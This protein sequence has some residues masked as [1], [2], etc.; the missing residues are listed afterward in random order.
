MVATHDGAYAVGNTMTKAKIKEGSSRRP[1]I[2]G[3]RGLAVLLVLVFHAGATRFRGGFI[4]VDVFFVISGFVIT[5]ALLRELESSG[6]IA[7]GTFYARRARR[8]IPLASIVVAI[9]VIASVQLLPVTTIADSVQAAISASLFTGNIFFANQQADYFASSIS[10]NPLLHYWSL[11]VEE[12][13]YLIWPAAMML[14]W[15]F[16]KTRFRPALTRLLVLVAAGSL[17]YCVLLAGS[18]PSAVFFLLPARALQLAAG[19]LLAL[20]IVRIEAGISTRNATIASV[21]GFALIMRSALSIATPESWSILNYLVPVAGTLLV[22]IGGRHGAGWWLSSAL[23]EGIGNISFSLYLIHW[24]L[25]TIT[26]ALLGRSLNLTET[27]LLLMLAGALALFA[28]RHLERPIRYS[29]R[30]N[31]AAWKGLAVGAAGILLSLSITSVAGAT[32]RSAAAAGGPAAAPRLEGFATGPQISVVPSNLDPALVDATS[33]RRS[34]L[35]LFGGCFQSAAESTTPPRDRCLFGDRT[36]SKAVAVLGDSHAAHWLPALTRLGAEQH[37]S[38]FIAAKENCSSVGGLVTRKQSRDVYQYCQ[39]YHEQTIA[40]IKE[41]GITSVILASSAG[42]L[43][44]QEVSDEY[45]AKLQELIA[46]F[47]SAAITSIVLGDSPTF[48][49]DVPTCLAIS[50][51]IS[52]CA[53]RIDSQEAKGLAVAE[54]N[55]AES[56]GAGYLSAARL[57]CPSDVCPLIAGNLLM[58]LDTNH[59]APHFATWFAPIL[60]KELLPL[61]R[62]E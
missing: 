6:K 45:T 24:P 41:S 61:L 21:V 10:T 13:F 16:F 31:T 8:I 34:A 33:V 19:S 57:L 2:D 58:Y 43:W 14:A 60:G 59:L 26:P 29:V 28:T 30:L 9:T 15:H 35:A 17:T 1:E 40:Y 5:A 49:Q 11:G 51:V 55:V 36:S 18:E 27:F 20:F 7:F 52:S 56:A 50:R 3:L 44:R 53:Q 46:E 42:Y 23:M 12:Q 62:L 54:R 37:F 22:I 4:G 47:E 48:R 38:L 32:T 25:L 39:T